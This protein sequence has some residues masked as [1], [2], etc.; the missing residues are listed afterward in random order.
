MDAGTLE[1]IF[2]PFFT[3]KAPGEG[4]GLGLSRAL[5]L[6]KEGN[7]YFTIQTTVGEGTTFNLYWNLYEDKANNKE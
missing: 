4:L 7:A 3:T 6:L 5:R 1:R 2:S